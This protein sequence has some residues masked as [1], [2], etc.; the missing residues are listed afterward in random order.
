M[1]D[2]SAATAEGGG[3]K[4]ACKSC[5]VSS[6]RQKSQSSASDVGNLKQIPEVQVVQDDSEL[7][8]RLLGQVSVNPNLHDKE[9]ALGLAASR[10]QTV[11]LLS[12]AA[13]A[14][15]E[16][17]TCSLLHSS[18][19]ASTSPGSHVVRLPTTKSSCKRRQVAWGWGGGHFAGGRRSTHLSACVSR[20]VLQTLKGDVDR[21]LQRRLPPTGGGGQ[22]T[23]KFHVPEEKNDCNS[24]LPE[25]EDLLQT[26]LDFLPVHLRS[27]P[28][29]SSWL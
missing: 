22:T 15:T 19:A 2:A 16:H 20:H 26:F 24:L 23:E 13:S 21:V 10:P 5:T 8:A 9:K 11:F 1:R 7:S 4:C 18:M 12:S 14:M 6:R 28:A 25:S 27:P 17:R 3:S 29:G